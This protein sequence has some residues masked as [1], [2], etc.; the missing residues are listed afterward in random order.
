MIKMAGSSRKDG[1]TLLGEHYAV[2]FRYDARSGKHVYGIYPIQDTVSDEKSWLNLP[3]LRGLVRLFRNPAILTAWGFGFAGIGGALLLGKSR[4]WTG[5]ALGAGLIASEYAFI[6]GMMYKVFGPGGHLRE[7]HGAEHKVINA[8]TL[9]GKELTPEQAAAA[10]RISRRC[11]TNFIVYYTAAGMTVGL[12]PLGHGVLQNMLVLGTAYEAF[13]LPE[14]KMPWL[15][16]KL[17]YAGDKLQ[18]FVTTAEPEEERLEAAR[19]GLNLLIKAEA[20]ELS[21]DEMKM[22]RENAGKRS[23]MDRLLG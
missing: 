5:K 14:E 10:S 2:T 22:Y 19:A 13:R 23:L 7:Y 20:G 9:S 1:M 6:L 18:Q 3:I 15:K 17:N 16:R 11:G 8:Y 12:L 4:H 21:E